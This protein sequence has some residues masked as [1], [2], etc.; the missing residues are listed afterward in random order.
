MAGRLIKG[1]AGQLYGDPEAVLI[2]RALKKPKL[3]REG[4]L[5][6]EVPPSSPGD[7]SSSLHHSTPFSSPHSTHS[8]SNSYESAELSS[9]KRPVADLEDFRMVRARVQ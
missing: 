2:Y 5:P 7:A 1:Y 4:L 3:M 8:S 9:K 6:E